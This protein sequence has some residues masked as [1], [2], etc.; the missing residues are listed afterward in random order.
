M[1][2]L[3]LLRKLDPDVEPRVFVPETPGYYR[4]RE[5]LNECGYAE[6]EMRLLA[7]SAAEGFPLRWRDF[8]SPTG[9]LTTHKTR[10]RTLGINTG[11]LPT[12]AP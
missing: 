5:I 1:M 12:G 8:G 10:W 6:I 3:H 2:R 9:R 4:A 11:R 7:L